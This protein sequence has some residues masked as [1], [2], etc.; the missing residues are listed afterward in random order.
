MSP[1]LSDGCLRGDA[2]AD[3]AVVASARALRHR[4]DRLTDGRAGA[5]QRALAEQHAL[6]EKRFPTPPA[7]VPQ[8]AS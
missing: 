5:A 8:S 4:L 6:M 2:L 3:A 7:Y 1:F